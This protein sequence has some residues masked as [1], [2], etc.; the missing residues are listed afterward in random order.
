MMYVLL[1]ITALLSSAVTGGL[2]YLSVRKYLDNEHKMRMLEMRIEERKELQRVVTPIRLQAY[3]RMALY[4]ER[5]SPENLVMRC[6]Q[7]GMDAAKLR[8]EMAK[9][10]RDEWEHNLSQQMY[11]DNEAWCAVRKAKEEIL[12]LV[13]ASADALPADA[14]PSSLAGSI[15][16]SAVKDKNPTDAAIN[17]LK[18]YLSE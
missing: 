8:G 10:I 13:N 2:M 6:Y 5:I 12:S 4:M 15:F 14:D 17:A 1:I 7:P 18:K 11:I 9:N 16:A 3:E